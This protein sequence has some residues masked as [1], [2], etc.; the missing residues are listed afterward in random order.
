[1]E[2]FAA[3]LRALATTA[4]VVAAVS[5]S[6]ASGEQRA[7]VG[8]DTGGDG[9]KADAGVVDRDGFVPRPSW[10]ET[11][12]IRTRLTGVVVVAGDVIDSW[13]CPW[14]SAELISR[15]S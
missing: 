8:S 6:E 3:A 10:G 4:V 14:P 12:S 15:N 11:A 5:S 2:L 1:M 7:V 13:C 9:V